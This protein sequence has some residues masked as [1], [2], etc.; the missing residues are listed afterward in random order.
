MKYLLVLTLLLI[1]CSKKEKPK[2]KVPMKVKTVKVHFSSASYEQVYPGEVR[3]KNRAELSFEVPGKLVKRPVI[4]GQLLKKGEFIAQLKQEDYKL[5]LQNSKAEFAQTRAEYERARVL[6]ASEAISKSEF[7]EKKALYLSAKSKRDLARKDLRDTTLKAPYDGKVAKFYAENFEDVKAKQP[8]LSYYN[9]KEFEVKINIPES[10]IAKLK[11]NTKVR[12]KA[13]L[14]DLPDKVLDLTFKEYSSKVDPKTRTFEAIF[15]IVDTKEVLLLPG[16]TLNVKANYY[17]PGGEGKKLAL[18]PSIC[19]LEAD[20]QSF[21]WVVNQKNMVLE[22]REIKI[23]KMKADKIEV[24][25][26]L[27]EGERV[28]AAGAYVLSEGDKVEYL[29]ETGGL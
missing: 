10:H 12:A 13:S 18:I 20:K 19:V 8:I 7:D 22:K 6:W 4:E 17:V 3:A 23:G 1:N 26:G 24:L 29:E 16:M 2:I 27:K 25:F 5:K 21:V 15:T 11:T 14:S 28:V 9:E